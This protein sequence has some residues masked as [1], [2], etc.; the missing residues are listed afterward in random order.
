MLNVRVEIKGDKKALAQLRT[1]LHVFE[2]WKPELTAVGEY[3]VKFYQDPAFETEG[4]IFGAR[5][6]ALT[7]AYAKRKATIYPGRG[8]LEA[9]GGLRR[10]YRK[11]VYSKLLSIINDDPKAE[12]HHLGK[13]RLPVR[14]IMK[15]DEPRKQEI[16]DIFKKGALIK[17]Q[18]AIKGA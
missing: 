8:I 3:L 7:P 13:G 4:G 15:V 2:D 14:V 1:M 17:V 6:V 18:K 10:A 12:L 5:W 9:S 16:V 11:E